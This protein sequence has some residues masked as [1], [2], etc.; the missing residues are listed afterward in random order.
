MKNRGNMIFAMILALIVIA[1]VVL[2][3]IFGQKN[4]DSTDTPAAADK[5]IKTSSDYSKID[6]TGQ[7]MLGD[8]D[9]PVTLV[10]FGDFKCPACKYFDMNIQPELVKKYVD[11]GELKMYF[12]NTP[13][14]GG[15]SLTGAHAAEAVLKNEPTKYW[16]FHNALFEAQPN[17]NTSTTDEWLTS[18]VVKAAAKKAGVKDITKIVKAAENKTETAAVEK[19]IELYQTYMINETPTIIVNG[20]K[21]SDQLKINAVEKAIEDA[22]K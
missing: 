15:E 22:K 3:V 17:T 19:D 1:A 9:A 21:V 12:I 7:P 6:T 8:K 18:A 13:F 4:N 5:E 11:K 2:M 10:E 16:A 20:K 14:H